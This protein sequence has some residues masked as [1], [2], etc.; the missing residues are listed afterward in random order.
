MCTFY[1]HN[2]GVEVGA[3]E[4]IEKVNI[5]YF[6]SNSMHNILERLQCG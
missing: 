3:T 6:G 4:I 1:I 5:I 2:F